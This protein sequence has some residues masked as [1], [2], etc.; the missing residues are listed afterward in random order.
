MNDSDQVIDH[1]LTAAL[2]VQC[3]FSGCNSSMDGAGLECVKQ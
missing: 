1:L 2:E 3:S